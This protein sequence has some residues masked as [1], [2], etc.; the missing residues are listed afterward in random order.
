M[1]E[2]KDETPKPWLRACINFAPAT[3]CPLAAP[4]A[5]ERWLPHSPK[6]SKTPV[7]TGVSKPFTAWDNV[8]LA[9]PCDPANGPYVMG[10]QEADVPDVIEKLTND[11]LDG[12]AATYP[13][14]GRDTND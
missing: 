1:T 4:S 6:R 10:V 9:P 2:A 11:D 8:T 3:G 13:M 5:V 12:L 7:S 14:P